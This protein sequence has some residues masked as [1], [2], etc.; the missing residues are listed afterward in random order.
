MNSFRNLPFNMIYLPLYNNNAEFNP[1]TTNILICT[2]TRMYRPKRVLKIIHIAYIV[3]V[4]TDHPSKHSLFI[5]WLSHVTVLECRFSVG[6]WTIYLLDNGR[7]G[8]LMHSN[9]DQPMFGLPWHLNVNKRAAY[10]IEIIWVSIVGRGTLFKS[11]CK[12]S[13]VANERG[14]VYVIYKPKSIMF[15]TTCVQKRSERCL[16][17]CWSLKLLQVQHR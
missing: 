15:K 16:A 14:G 2:V 7:P 6:C 4:D 10:E 1:R 13:K 9:L 17:T 8:S 12:A 3:M 11:T 5:N